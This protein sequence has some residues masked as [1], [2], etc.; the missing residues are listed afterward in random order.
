M[1]LSLLNRKEKLKFLDLAV[2]MVDIDGTPSQIEKRLLRLIF[3]EVSD[4]S[5]EYTFA[6]SDSIDKTIEYFN[7]ST[8][9]VKNII[10]L[11]LMKITLEDD[12]YNTSEFLFLEKIQNSFG[13]SNEKR[14][15]IMGVVYEE[16]DLKER[17][18]RVISY[19]A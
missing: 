9:P 3:A 14:H 4:V 18:K 6:K 19:N 15:E 17:A 11:N 13:I 16:R 1:F 10:Y 2:N 8:Q 12:F 7:D 5:E